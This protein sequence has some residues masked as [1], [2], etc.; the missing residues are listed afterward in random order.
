MREGQ[1]IAS[2]GSTGRASGPHLHYELRYGGKLVNP[3][4]Y[5]ISLFEDKGQGAA[6][7]VN[8]CRP[9]VDLRRN[10]TFL[11]G[12]PQQFIK[13]DGSENRDIQSITD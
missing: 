10:N 8:L 9:T 13:N 3:A 12:H 7:S 4:I 11:T 6:A 2:L 5:P 1:Q